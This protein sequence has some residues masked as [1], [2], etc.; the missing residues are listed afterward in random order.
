M[1]MRKYMDL[2]VSETR[3]HLE[4]AAEALVHL[5]QHP[6]DEETLNLLFRHGH[7]IQGM[8][9]SMGFE[10]IA[11]LSHALED[12][13]DQVRK[14]HLRF[15]PEI[16][17]HAF[18]AL[19]ALSDAISTAERGVDPPANLE[20]C[21]ASL[22][23]FLDSPPPASRPVASAPQEQAPSLPPAAIHGDLPAFNAEIKARTETICGPRSCG[24]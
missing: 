11:R 6:D 5:E 7:S 12:L 14:G 19:D 17:D 20:K 9:G 4:E 15:T 16:A 22:R 8:A 24:R 23:S 1:D 2:F 10:P 21:V 18:Q 3:E 13:F